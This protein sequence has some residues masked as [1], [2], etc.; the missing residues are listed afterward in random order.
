MIKSKIGKRYLLYFERMS[1]V[2]NA[3]I[4]NDSEYNNIDAPNLFSTKKI[5]NCSFLTLCT[6]FSTLCS[7]HLFVPF[8]FV[9]SLVNYFI[10]T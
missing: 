8:R 2:S 6:F 4:Q 1:V 7:Y 9:L 3:S 5:H 10:T